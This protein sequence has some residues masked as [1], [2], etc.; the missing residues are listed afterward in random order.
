[1]RARLQGDAA[2]VGNAYRQH[3]R[4]AGNGDDRQEDVKLHGGLIG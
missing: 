4:Q 3:E 1:M 2:F